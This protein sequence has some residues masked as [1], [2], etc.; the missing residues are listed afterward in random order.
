MNTKA[1]SKK[2][3]D[4]AQKICN[5]AIVVKH[6]EKLK[7]DDMA[8]VLLR[9][10]Q[11]WVANFAPPESVRESIKSAGEVLILSAADNKKGKTQ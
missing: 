1:Q 11:F 2:I 3:D 5:I 8:C 6:N 9:A 4:V 10:F 7:P